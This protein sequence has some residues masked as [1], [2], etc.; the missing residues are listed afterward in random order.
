MFIARGAI[1]AAI[2]GAFLFWLKNNPFVNGDS[3][4]LLLNT[5]ARYLLYYYLTKAVVRVLFTPANE[6]WRIIEVPDEC[7]K[8]ISSSLI[9]SS[10]AICI[11][12][13]SK[14]LPII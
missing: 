9:F 8:A 6:K 12:S 11:V 4:G 10:A 7:A 5:A 13:F 14:V 2:I 1:P 3:F